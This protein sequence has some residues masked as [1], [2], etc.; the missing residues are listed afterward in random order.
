MKL[1]SKQINEIAQNLEAGMKVY[2]N[3]DTLEFRTILDWDEISDPELWDEE[4][5]KIESEWD[6]YVVIEKMESRDAFRIM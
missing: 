4:L 5:E 3:S 2:I 6:D 1:T